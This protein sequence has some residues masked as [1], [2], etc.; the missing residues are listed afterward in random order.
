MTSPIPRVESNNANGLQQDI[1]EVTGAYTPEVFAYRAEI[2][3]LFMAPVTKAAV[4]SSLQD[5]GVAELAD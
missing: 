3:G 1:I 5:Y 2:S 4:T